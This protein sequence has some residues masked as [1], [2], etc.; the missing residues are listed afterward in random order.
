[1]KKKIK[2]FLLSIIYYFRGQLSY[3]QDGE[4]VVLAALMDKAKGYKGFFIDVGAHHPVRFSNTHFYYKKGW[5]GINI[6]PTPGSMR[7]FRVFRRDDCNLEI[8]I[9]GEK[10][11][12]EF[13]LFN[14][15][16]LNTF[17][18]E[19]AKKRNGLGPYR[20]IKSVPVKIEPLSQVCDNWVPPGKKI[21]FLSVDAEGFDFEI[22]QSNDWDRY[23][24]DYILVEDDP[25]L[26]NE[27]WTSPVANYLALR[28]YKLISKLK[29]TSIY[30][31]N[32]V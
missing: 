32:S 8:G 31:H 14:E 11:E 25:V 24:P 26:Q 18:S 17:N 22:L 23:I 10:G 28:G 9:G 4:D 2:D 15:P 5:R 19:L 6:D 7:G 3:A 27:T 21:D 13:F 16:A 12:I 30:K 29:R 20:L 1:M